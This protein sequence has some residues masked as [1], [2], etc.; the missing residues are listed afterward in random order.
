MGKKE[1]KEKKKFEEPE[2]YQ[3]DDMIDE[4]IE[5]E[6]DDEMIDDEDFSEEE[7]EENEEEQPKK[8]TKLDEKSL[9]RPPTNN[10]MQNLKQ[11][12]EMFKS[13]LF[14]LQIEELIKQVEFNPN[15]NNVVQ[16]A[17]HEIKDILDGMPEIEPKS[18]S[19]II[20]SMKKSGIAIPFAPPKDTLLKFAFKKPDSISIV[21][22]FLLQTMTKRKE[23][24][25]V[26]IAITMP[27]SLFLD[28]DHV[29]N[30][31]FYKRAYYLSVV[32]SIL[33]SKGYELEF[34]S[35][36]NDIK[37]PILIVKSTV[38]SGEVFSK[39][40][41]APQ[42]NNVR[43][44]SE[45]GELVPTPH[46]N[47]SLL[48]DT[49]MVSHLNFIHSS[50][51]D[52]PALKHAIILS[53][54]WI[55]QRGLSEYQKN[56]FGLSGF[57]ISMI[58][59]ALLKSSGK[60]GTKRIAKGFSSY[61]MLKITLDL[62]AHHDFSRSPL[63]LSENFE[64]IEKEEFSSEYF[65][66]NYDIAIVDPSGTINIAAHITK[67]AMDE[68]QYEAKLTLSFFNDSTSDRFED[69][70]LKNVDQ[71]W[72]KYDN[73]FRIPKLP[74]SLASYT[75]GDS[76]DLADKTSFCLRQLYKILKQGLNKRVLSISV[77]TPRLKNWK[78]NES[79]PNG[80]EC[81]NIT[82]GMILHPEN[83][84]KEVEQ[85]PSGDDKEAVKEFKRI[86]GGKS[87]LRRYKDGSIL[88]SVVFSSDGSIQSRALLVARMT[89][90]LLHFHFS[91]G[92]DDGVTYW[93]GLGNKYLNP[94]S[95]EKPTNSYQGVM[96]AYQDLI[97]E[98]KAIDL[99]LSI[100]RIHPLTDSLTYSSVFVPQPDDPSAIISRS[101]PPEF[102]IEFE[103]SGK[104][105]D[106][107]SAI[108]T[109]KRAFYI[110]IASSLAEK[111]SETVA[112]V[113]VGMNNESY[114][115]IVH[116]SGYLFKVRIYVGRII[117]LLENIVKIAP[118]HKKPGL[119]L[120]KQNYTTDNINRPIHASLIGNLCLRFP[121]LGFTIR[122]AK[123]WMASQMLLSKFESGI[124][125]EVV[126][127][128]CVRIYT[129]PT[130]Y[131][132]PASGWVGFVRFLE[133][134]STFK[135]SSEPFIVELES[136]KLNTE[137]R[138]EINAKFNKLS[139]GGVGHISMFVAT[140]LDHSSS[141]W[142]TLDISTKVV[143]KFTILA[144]SSLDLIKHVLTSVNY[145][146]SC[147]PVKKSKFK[148]VLDAHDKKLIEQSFINVQSRYL[149]ELVE[150]FG[151][152]ALFFADVYGGDKICVVWKPGRLEDT[153]FKANLTFN[154]K[155]KTSKE[156]MLSSF[157]DKNL[158]DLF[159][160][161]VK[162]IHDIDNSELPSRDELYQQQVF[163][164]VL[165][166]QEIQVRVE[167]LSLFSDNE[168]LEDINT[169]DLKYLLV[170]SYLGQ[171]L[172]KINQPRDQILNRAQMFLLKFWDILDSYGIINP[173]DKQRF[174][175]YKEDIKPKGDAIR[176]EKIKQYKREKETKQKLEEL[177][178]LLKQELK[179][180]TDYERELILTTL[181]LH[182][183]QAIKLLIE[184]KD[185]Q[186]LL[187]YAEK[188]KLSDNQ[189]RVV[190]PER[191]VKL[192]DLT[193][194][195]LDKQGKPLRPFVITTEQNKREEL[196]NG[197]F[198]PG[199]ILP[200]MTI[201]EYLEREIER[202]NFLSGGTK[203]PVKED[204]DD[205]DEEAIDQETYKKR[206]WDNFTDFNPRGWG[207]RHNKG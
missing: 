103:T 132:P 174:N 18:A 134:V 14:K 72:L 121:F 20:S 43:P 12:S 108:E 183:Q 95:H 189:D 147:A 61:Q 207:N 137:I 164:T 28:K 57:L 181:D 169:A 76:L 155:L 204:P 125:P 159:K 203:Q 93:A 113:C 63:F 105:P 96:D 16:N 88:E 175:N 92:E 145:D 154:A 99:R 173:T 135:W 102:L 13:N 69:L 146:P 67:S 50:L 182:V 205:N 206:E 179:D 168:I 33:K 104:W 23:N 54:V 138:D 4:E 86:W 185:E 19:Q 83:S 87:E 192:A 123:R 202:G 32:A 71:P 199:H 85:G 47:A 120:Y 82:I 55:A 172:L 186:E 73:I 84:I 40:K 81:T 187:K 66:E 149:N 44:P 109:M 133:M 3:D 128:L 115:Q 6:M 111:E 17:L 1:K 176:T 59:A 27:S 197:V 116:S 114:L 70:F 77:S 8:K 124:P 119:A 74:K 46:Y 156:K 34:Q 101:N 136:E 36:Q 60:N 198:R 49:E 150:Y 117:Y 110:K 130:A 152:I 78:I 48:Q 9:Y 129:Q 177:N 167:S 97:K 160:A 157:E 195:M 5:E 2:E 52:A 62:L 26:D 143:Q 94:K 107:I 89:A 194:P 90:Y 80:N 180:E 188:M 200:T 142:N 166:L 153:H 126:E 196:A 98:L 91:V 148:N 11:T 64:P 22:S 193:G 165:L 7:D 25:N 37:R 35:F 163:Q 140:E 118:P 158:P 79:G 38:L 151:D 144:K 139:A 170:Q 30:R 171:T 21:G 184:I 24:V 190:M 131:G 100:H 201:E 161:A 53:K 65:L 10:E 45:E 127:L 141:W 112:T 15:K 68:I 42:R 39:A 41:L 106:D 162:Q 122:L 191:T 58:M 31:Y 56:G 178:E 29:N 75:L 51:K